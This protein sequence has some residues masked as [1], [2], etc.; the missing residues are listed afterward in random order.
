[1]LQRIV[2]D[3]PADNHAVKHVV[4]D[5]LT[6]LCCHSLGKGLKVE[7]VNA[8]DSLICPSVR[9]NRYIKHHVTPGVG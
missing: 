6:V 9:V 8:I 3:V 2:I 1:M 4:T 5:N 7:S